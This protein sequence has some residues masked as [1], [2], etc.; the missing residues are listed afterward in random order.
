MSS[1]HDPAQK[2]MPTAIGLSPE[3]WLAGRPDPLIR[4]HGLIGA[5]VSRV[6]GPLKVAGKARF[7]AEVAM[8]GLT[9]AALVYS[10]IAR[11]RIERIA[12]AAAEAA[13]G[14]V[15]VMT[16]QNAPRMNPP[17]LFGTSPSAAG[18]S[19]LPIMQDDEHP[20]EW[21]SGGLGARRDARSRLTMQPH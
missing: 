18:P 19:T 15:L 14:V 2:E 10:T 11:G 3:S 20:L 8:D 9:Y 1:R 5:P 12:A 13:P 7:A 16:Y 6:D 17:A 21:R 4:K